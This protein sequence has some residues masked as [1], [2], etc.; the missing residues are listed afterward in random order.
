MSGAGAA[1]M[2]AIAAFIFWREPHRLAGFFAR[3]QSKGFPS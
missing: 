3:R 2:A 1:A